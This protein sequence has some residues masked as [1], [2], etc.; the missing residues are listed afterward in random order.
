VVFDVDGTLVDSE[1]EGHRVAFNMAFSEA[2]LSHH[3]DVETYGRLLEI[4]GGQRRLASFLR[5]YGHDQH[6]ADGLA[7]KLHRSK[8]RSLA[9]IIKSGG[10]SLRPGVRTLVEGL[11]D[12]GIRMFIATTGSREWVVPLLGQHFEAAT[13]E[14]MV[15][16][17]DV[18]RLKPDPEVYLKTLSIAG[19]TPSGV[20]AVEDSRNGLRSAHAAGLNCLVVVNDYTSDDDVTAA[21][22]VVDGFGPA[23]RRLSGRMDVPIPGGTVT[24]ETLVALAGLSWLSR[25]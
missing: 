3:W 9:E 11:R 1:R 19:L 10:I 5:E 18:E 16:G 17:S 12:H 14:L 15:T 22:L 20:I 13:F 25:A 8:N 23:A 24:F 7:A 4:T 21:A 2:G 6:D